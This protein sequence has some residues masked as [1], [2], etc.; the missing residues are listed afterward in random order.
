MQSQENQIY[1]GG[2]EA[3]GAQAKR[4]QLSRGCKLQIVLQFTVFVFQEQISVISHRN[5]Y[6]C[7]LSTC[8]FV[9]FSERVALF[10]GK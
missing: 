6:N 9:S 2:P 8:Y 5:S 4:R 3:S 10:L 1:I 7:A